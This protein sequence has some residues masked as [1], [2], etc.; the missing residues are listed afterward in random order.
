MPLNFTLSRNFIKQAVEQLI[1][2]KTMEVVHDALGSDLHQGES[3]RLVVIMGPP[4]NIA[5]E[6]N[7]VETT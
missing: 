5:T 6:Q 4:L 7:V 3:V 1:T 2:Q